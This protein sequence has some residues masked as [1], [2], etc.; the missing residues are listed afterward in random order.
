MHASATIHRGAY[1]VYR[2]GE[3]ENV[4]VEDAMRR[5]LHGWKMQELK[6]ME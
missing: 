5:K 1:I 6:S 3:V 2:R 4:A